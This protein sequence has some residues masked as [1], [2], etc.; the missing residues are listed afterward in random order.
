ME[1]NRQSPCWRIVLGLAL[2]LAL[3]S[4]PVAVL[5]CSSET[6]RTPALDGTPA[7]VA[8]T[9]GTAGSAG[10][11][12]GTQPGAFDAAVRDAAVSNAGRGGDA[13]VRD[14]AVRDGAALDAARDA[15]EPI[16]SGP[17]GMTYVYLSGY[18]ANIHVFELDLTTG[19]LVARGT[20]NGG[21]SPSYLAIA[22][23]ERTLYA[24]NEVEPSS[25]VVAF[26]IDR[27][28][29]ALT[30]INRAS[31]GGEGA[32]H[33]AVH[34][35]GK[36]VAVA[37]YGSGHTTVLPVLANGGVGAPV[38]SERG[39]NNGC[40]RA[41]QAVFDRAG[42]HLFV[43]CLESNYVLQFSFDASDGSL[44]YNDP[45]TAAV[46]GGPRHMVLHPSERYAYVLSE[47]ASTITSFDYDAAGGKLS[48]PQVIDSHQSMPGASAHIAVHPNGRF[49]YASNRNENSLG[50]FVLDAN[51]RPTAASFAT[52]MIDTPRDFAI[53]PSGAFLIAANQR[54]AQN[55]LVFRIDPQTGAL[56]RVQVV[57]VGDSP[58]FVGFAILR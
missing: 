16:D 10:G 18:G 28:S 49:L 4:V 50:A 19:A 22:P 12:G 38:A 3:G 25:E 14:A 40:S 35:S 48:N 23:D 13:A 26:A 45:P 2:V 43:P 17:P 21:E 9:S 5:G 46:T 8:G 54:G 32:P 20:A 53:D 6:P 33:L 34:P 11:T 24:I 42:T 36:W 29:G 57:A 1:P 47:T 55:A 7:P 37:H 15:S 44:A 30:E 31:S 56:T 41:H 27:A 51:G 52:E 39:P 58:S